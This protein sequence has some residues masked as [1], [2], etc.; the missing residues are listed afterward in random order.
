MIKKARDLRPGDVMDGHRVMQ[1]AE[2]EEYAYAIWNGMPI[3]FEPDADVWVDEEASGESEPVSS[4]SI[5]TVKKSDNGEYYVGDGNRICGGI[6]KH[7][8]AADRVCRYPNSLFAQRQVVTK[9]ARDLRKGDR[10]ITTVTDDLTVR[11][12]NCQ[13]RLDDKRICIFHANEEVQ[14]LR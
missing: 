10:I 11:L 2:D 14:V 7:W 9:R 12:P 3:T 4:A 5:F 6:W 1:V 8:T 13:L